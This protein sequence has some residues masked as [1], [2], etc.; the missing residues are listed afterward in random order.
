MTN[1][2]AVQQS[3]TEQQAA[4]ESSVQHMTKAQKREA[5][6]LAKVEAEKREAEAKAALEA[7]LL[8]AAVK[9]RNVVPAHYRANYVRGLATTASGNPT[10]DNNDDVAA[11]LRGMAIEGVYGLAAIELGIPQET[12]REQY[13]HLNVGMQR[14]NLGNRVR[15]I[16]KLK[17]KM[18]AQAK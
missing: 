7:E 11:Q 9:G 3:S 13:A 6:R 8:A 17:A 12:L 18:A 2:A 16:R 10:V 4:A 1:Q 15:G 5:Q 14:M